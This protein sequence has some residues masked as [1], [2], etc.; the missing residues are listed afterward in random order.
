M[1]ASTSTAGSGKS[2]S[3]AKLGT[4]TLD[5]FDVE[6]MGTDYNASSKTVSLGQSSE[7]AEQELKGRSVTLQAGYAD[8]GC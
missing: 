6:I 8:P 7:I 3:V 4:I 5:V 2:N 1:E